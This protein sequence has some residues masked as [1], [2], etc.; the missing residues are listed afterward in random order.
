MKK[1][2]VLGS[3]NMDLVVRAPRHPQPGE[4]VIGGEFQT[5][6]GGKGANQ[7]VAAARLGAEVWMIGRVGGD[8][9]GE[10]LLQ[11]VR[12]DGVNT[13]FVRCD[14]QAATG[15]ALITLDTTG[16]NAIVVAPGANMRLT[17]QDVQEAEAAFEGADLLLMQLESP[18]EAV[19]AALQIAHRRGAKV[20]LNP[21]PARPLPN[22]L[23]TQ[24]DYLVPN[25]SELRLLAD[26]EVEIEAAAARLMA[27]GVRNLI[28]TLGEEGALLKTADFQEKLPAFPVPV[29]DTVAAGDA[30]AAAFC[31]ALAEGKPLREAVVWGNAAGAIAVTR[32]GAQPS[33]PTR[34][35]L[36]HFLKERQG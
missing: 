30:F 12:R 35:E 4:T 15:V 21:A 23:L 17:V 19:E 24:V 6:P 28:V 2:V 34:E 20:V 29:V 9:F 5:F 18:L 16:Q 1:I 25:Q 13:T 14:D 26:G 32:P 27:K 33:M 11:T 10:A 3:L 31:V 22:A 8:A 36:E 7:A